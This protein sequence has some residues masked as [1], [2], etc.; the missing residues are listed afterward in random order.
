MIAIT[1]RRIEIPSIL[2]L[3]KRTEDGRSLVLDSFA[4]PAFDFFMDTR[5]WI[6][7]EK[8][9][10]M[11]IRIIFGE[12]GAIQ[13][14]GR[15]DNSQLHPQLVQHL[16]ED[17]QMNEQRHFPVGTILFGEGYGAGIQKGGGNY[18][19]TKRFILLDIWSGSFWYEWD[20]MKEIAAERDIPIVPE[21][22]DEVF[23]SGEYHT[24]IAGAPLDKIE[25][26]IAYGFKSNFG[27][28]RAEGVVV[29]PRY[30]LFDSHGR[31]IL[32]KIKTRDYWI[33]A[34]IVDGF[35]KRAF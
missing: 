35:G 2:N 8:I 31:R 23:H 34:R 24:A 32:I 27:D 9:D 30:N 33:K 18:S 1:E 5:D 29:R 15:T 7:T 19:D 4:N 16:I 3:R 13:F 11:N 17:F 14:F 25:N 12:N 21:Y 22:H 20:D 26:I 6:V 28:F 10:G